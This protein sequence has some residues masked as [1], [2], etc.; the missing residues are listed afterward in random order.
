MLKIIIKS[1]CQYNYV[2]I[3]TYKIELKKYDDDKNS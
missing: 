1:L 2:E 3:V